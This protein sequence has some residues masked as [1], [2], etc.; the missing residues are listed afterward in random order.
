MLK[1]LNCC[2]RT[3]TCQN[4]QF[5]SLNYYLHKLPSLT[6]VN[7]SPLGVY[8]ISAIVTL[9]LHGARLCNSTLPSALP[10]CSKQTHTYNVK[11][12]KRTILNNICQ[13]ETT[14]FSRIRH[15]TKNTGNDLF[16]SA[17]KHALNVL[18]SISCKNSET[19]VLYCS[20]GK[21]WLGDVL[22]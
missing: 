2:D 6:I 1:I 7:I 5:E 18:Y 8:A 9:V 22:T 3:M 20:T 17:F 4:R 13:I 21:I 16:K 11:R 10:S 15:G 14:K 19:C 12:S